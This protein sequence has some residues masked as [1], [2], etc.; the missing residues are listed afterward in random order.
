MRLILFLFSVLAL[1]AGSGILAGAKS[2]IHEI[3]AFI[4]FLIAAVLFSAAAVIDSIIA[5]RRKLEAVLNPSDARKPKTAKGALVM[6][7]DC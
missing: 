7:P 5:N 6:E 2:A 3:E 1:L 4:L